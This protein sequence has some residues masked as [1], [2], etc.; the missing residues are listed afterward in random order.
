MFRTVNGAALLASALLVLVSACGGD[1]QT[2]AGGGIDGTGSPAQF[3]EGVITKGS[4]ILNGVRYDDSRAVVLIDGRTTNASELATGMFVKL[5]GTVNA[6]RSS[7]TAEQVQ[8]LNEVFGAISAINASAEP[9]SFVA[10][11]QTV[12]VDASTVFVNVAG[13]AGLDVG[14]RVEVYGQRD[15]T[16]AIHASRV[17]LVDAGSADQLRG[18]VASLDGKSFKL[19]SVK[20]DFGGATIDPPGAGIANGQQVEVRGTFNAA[21]G[22]FVASHVDREDLEDT[23]VQPGSGQKLEVEGFISAFDAG[24]STFIVNKRNVRYSD[25]TRFEDGTKADLANNVKVE[26]EG[27]V[28]GAGVLVAT[29]IE[30]KKKR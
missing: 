16:G 10:V 21:S 3:S 24:A 4:V 23:G 7:G 13:L 25:A 19:G 2:L 28:D 17:E 5:R 9:A 18:T 1:G 26:A 8:V 22:V 30:V 14:V 6:D 29:K 11:G 20:V 12:L 15:A 27:R